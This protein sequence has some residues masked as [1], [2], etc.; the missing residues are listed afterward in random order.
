MP[1]QVDPGEPTVAASD[2]RR[3]QA[4]DY[5]GYADLQDRCPRRSGVHYWQ[6]SECLRDRTEL[7]RLDD[8]E[9][10]A[11]VTDDSHFRTLGQIGM[12]ERTLRSRMLLCHP[13]GFRPADVDVDDCHVDAQR[14]S[15][16]TWSRRC[17]PSVSQYSEVERRMRV[18]VHCCWHAS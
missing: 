8:N 14:S 2:G 15:R 3:H 1:G 16:L 12:Q 5:P 7:C 13:T 6:L 18:A 17:S 11:T 9:C 4:S 10:R